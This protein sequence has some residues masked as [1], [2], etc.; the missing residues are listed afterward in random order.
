MNQHLRLT[1]ATLG[2]LFALS[3]A[4]N[5]ATI[6]ITEFIADPLGPDQ[7][8]PEWIEL[9]N[10]GLSAVDIGGWTLKDNS[11]GVYTFPAGFTIASGD[12]AIAT[13]STT[14]SGV[15]TGV[16]RQNFIDRWLGGVDDSRVVSPSH[17]FQLNNSNPGDG[18]YLRDASSNL[19]WSLGYNGVPTPYRATFLTIN[20]FSVTNYGVPPQDGAA[21]INRNGIDGT[22]T[23]GYE[24]NN[25]TA[26]PKMYLSSN[27][28]DTNQQW[29]SPLLGTY[30]VIPE[31]SALALLLA[32][33][34][35]IGALGRR[36]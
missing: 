6:A 32:A 31:P 22:G 34:T 16:G 9:Y 17:T 26:D 5:A 27:S 18:I 12:Y 30:T 14:S 15:P 29:G 35:G 20:D 1:L 3:A 4:S 7:E 36:R 19:V 8:A 11:S 13:V 28:T 24:D 2:L 21:L 10:Y 23:L 33:C 25:N